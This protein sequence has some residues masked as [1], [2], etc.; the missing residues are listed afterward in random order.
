MD[1]PLLI[2]YGSQTGNAQDVA[3]RVS[4][5]GQHMLF[6]TRTM[7][8]DSYAV[9]QLPQE[10]AVVFVCATSG[11]GEMPDNMKQ[12][13]RFLLRKN[14][15]PDSLSS[16]SYAV[17]GLGDSGYPQYNPRLQP[18]TRMITNTNTN[19]YTNADTN[20]N[21]NTYTNADTNTNTNTYT[22]ADTNNNAN[23]YT[24][25]D[26]NTKTNT[27]TNAD[28]N[29][30]ANTYTNADTNNNSNT[31]SNS[32]SSISTNTNLS[33]DRNKNPELTE[34]TILKLGN[35]KYKVS[36]SPRA[37]PPASSAASDP[38]PASTQLQQQ[39]G[40]TAASFRRLAAQVS[41]STLDVHQKQQQHQ[42]NQPNEQNS[43]SA[44]APWVPFRAPVL[45]N[46]KMTSANHFQ[47]VRHISVSLVGSGLQ[48]EPGDLLAVM[49]QSSQ[50][51]VDALVDRLG[52][53]ADAEVQVE[54]ASAEGLPPRTETEVVRSSVRDLLAAVVDVAGASPRRFFFEVLQHF[55]ESELEKSR[56]EYFASA[57]G[58]DDVYRYNAR[59]GRTV[60]EVLQDFK[61]VKLPLEWLLEAAPTMKPRL[62]SISSSAR[63]HPGEAH[64]TVAVVDYTN[65]NTN[66]PI[67]QSTTLT[68]PSRLHP[69]EAHLTV[70]VVDYTN[71]NTNVPICQSTTLT[72]P[73]RLH[74]V[75]YTTPFK[76]NKR[77]L[78]SSYLADLQPGVDKV[79]VWTER[80]VLRMPQ[81][82]SIPLILVG[83]GTEERCVLLSSFSD[84][85]A[86]A[87]GGG[88]APQH[89]APETASASS[90]D[91]VHPT[92]PAP[93]FLFFGCRGMNSD[94]LYRQQWESHMQQGVLG[95]SGGSLP[96]LVVA[97]SRDQTRS[98]QKMPADVTAAFE[99]VAV[100]HGALS[101]EE[102][103]SWI[104]RME[105]SG[106]FVIEA[107]S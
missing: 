46:E 87:T 21:A 105:Q 68:I 6:N 31:K 50:S 78:C 52:L 74:P 56:L 76:R 35:P 73:S 65:H 51:A 99:D 102:A 79:P 71:H 101:K 18:Y 3:E 47:D 26:T 91:E 20:N 16:M 7:A 89:I 14:L 37:S 12:S 34:S 106:R 42:Q 9:T 88:A 81:D 84:G 57:E 49:P 36:F 100:A 62:F 48:Y 13:W 60:L 104:K 82:L 8:M 27:Y 33:I 90:P 61:S 103:K 38:A 77:G 39:L 11:Q 69:G 86:Q 1:A 93:C 45:V 53:D 58:R 30:N 41:G 24:N 10:Q 94:C 70:A 2:L 98:A 107:W 19:T 75:D 67:C 29:N 95:H 55:A 66:V 40:P 28:T 96:G 85:A 23:T 83:P 97:A 63:L 44:Y 17:F 64:L 4:R 5:E 59:E 25:A 92:L 80:G 32:N 72:I 43:T 22:N 15:P 54:A